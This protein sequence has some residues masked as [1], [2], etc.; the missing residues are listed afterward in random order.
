[1][2]P[3][4]IPIVHALNV[5]IVCPKFLELANTWTRET[6]YL[7]STQQMAKH[8][9][10]LEIVRMGTMVVP[11]IFKELERAPGFR[12]FHAL[13]DILGAGPEIPTEARGKLGPV[14]DCW[15]CW[16]KEHGISW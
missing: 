15:L 12:W 1:M 7:S 16:G 8:P 13:R 2:S 14:T 5:P 10:Y 11:L 3:L 9:A 4:S 6:V